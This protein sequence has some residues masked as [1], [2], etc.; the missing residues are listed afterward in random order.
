[1]DFK[2]SEDMA[3]LLIIVEIII[4][5]TTIIIFC[6]NGPSKSLLGKYLI[7]YVFFNIVF[8]I[9]SDAM[10]ASVLQA[11]Q[12]INDDYNWLAVE[13]QFKIFIIF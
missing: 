11:T 9:Q 8:Q 13:K 2:I 10:D 1:M 4:Y 3:V 6:E 5:V 7:L 12:Y